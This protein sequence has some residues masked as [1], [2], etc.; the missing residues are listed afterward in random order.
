[1]QLVKSY[2]INRDSRNNFYDY[3]DIYYEMLMKLLVENPNLDSGISHD[4]KLIRAKKL[5]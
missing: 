4:A 5:L 2:F 1:M 3:F